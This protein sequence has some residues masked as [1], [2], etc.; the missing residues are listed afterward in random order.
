[1]DTGKKTS[2]K[3]AQFRK[4]CSYIQAKPHVCTL[5]MYMEIST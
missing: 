4:M 1:M 2:R 5:Y 3:E